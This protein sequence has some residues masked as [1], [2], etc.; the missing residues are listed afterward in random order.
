MSKKPKAPKSIFTIGYERSRLDDFL[1]ALRD[2][3]VKRVLDV[4]DVAWSRRPEYAKGRLS[5]ALAESSIDYQ[6]LQALGVPK[7]GR[8]AIHAGRTKE[9]LAIY[10][11]RLATP[12][13]EADLARAIELCAAE[14]SCLLCYEADP[15]RCHRSIAAARI[16][17]VTGQQIEPLSV[18]AR[19]RAKT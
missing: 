18:P 6:H 4:R 16:T 15:A 7:P 3:G 14:P 2:A 13:A 8:D 10:E 1:A 9:F 12:E 17:E 19:P 5:T 11:A